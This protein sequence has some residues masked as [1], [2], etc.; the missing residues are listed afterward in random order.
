MASELR[1]PFDAGLSRSAELQ[2]GL[3][4]NTEVDACHLRQTS[5]KHRGSGHIVLS[6]VPAIE[7]FRVLRV[8]SEELG[9][10]QA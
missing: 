7:R 4:V 10:K 2:S 5:S 3:G 9:F 8:W 1:D 6:R